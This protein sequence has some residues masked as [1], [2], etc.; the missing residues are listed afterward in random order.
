MSANA[1]NRIISTLHRASSILVRNNIRMFVLPSAL[2]NLTQPRNDVSCD[3][4]RNSVAPG[5]FMGGGEAIDPPKTFFK[6]PI[7]YTKDEKARQR[8]T[9]SAGPARRSSH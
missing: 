7:D 3:R 2:K 8:G 9:S 4:V 1:I 5:G 6:F